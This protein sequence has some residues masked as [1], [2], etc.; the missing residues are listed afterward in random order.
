MARVKAED[1]ARLPSF[2][3]GIFCWTATGALALGLII[4]LAAP[5]ALRHVTGFDPPTRALAAL[6]LWELLPFM[7]LTS[8]SSVLLRALRRWLERETVRASQTASA[9]AQPSTER[10]GSYR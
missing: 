1:P 9:S 7:V 8:A 5:L 6:Y 3:G 2:V 10:P 4:C